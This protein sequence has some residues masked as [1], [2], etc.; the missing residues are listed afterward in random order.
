M[1]YS[2]RR[3]TAKYRPALSP[4]GPSPA[5][6]PPPGLA[7]GRRVALA[8]PAA[9]A[10]A[11]A[12]VAV[13]ATAAA[14]AHTAASPATVQRRTHTPRRRAAPGRA[15]MVNL[16]MLPSLPSVTVAAATVNAGV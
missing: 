13:N 12:G 8:W 5:V 11:A 4:R 9:V 16:I 7:A 14:I 10:V 3:I 15:G 2:V 6:R 1:P